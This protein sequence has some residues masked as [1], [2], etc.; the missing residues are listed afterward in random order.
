MRTLVSMDANKED[1]K[2]R[3]GSIKDIKKQRD[4]RCTMEGILAIRAKNEYCKIKKEEQ[5]NIKK[6]TVEMARYNPKFF[7]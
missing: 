5:R 3:S 1:E 2:K 7:H 6:T 4:Q